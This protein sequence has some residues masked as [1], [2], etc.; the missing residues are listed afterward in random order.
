MGVGIKDGKKKTHKVAK[1]SCRNTVAFIDF[2]KFFSSCFH[3]ITAQ[4][5]IYPVSYIDQN[6]YCLTYKTKLV[7]S[8]FN[9]QY[10]LLFSFFG[11]NLREVKFQSEYNYVNE[12]YLP[13]FFLIRYFLIKNLHF[14]CYPKSP[15]Y[16]PHHFPTHPLL[17]LGPGVPFTEAYKVCKTNGPLFPMMAE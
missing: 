2:C 10:T 6:V 15:P 16:P 8:H 17:L 7:T 5:S 11:H 4:W 14:Q 12:S 9:P 3:T 1:T 13:G